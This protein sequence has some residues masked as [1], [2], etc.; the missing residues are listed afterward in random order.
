MLRLLIV[1]AFIPAFVI[2]VTAGAG[3]AGALVTPGVTKGAII[4]PAA[5]E[6]A[7]GKPKKFKQNKFKAQKFKQRKFK[8]GKAPG[9]QAIPG[10]PTG[11]FSDLEKQITRDFFRR[12]AG[13]VRGKSK[14]FPPGLAKRQTLPPGL[15]MQIQRNGILPPGLAKRTLPLGLASNL[16]ALPPG[17]Q[18][19]I[20]GNDVVLVQRST[21]LILDVLRG[22][23]ASR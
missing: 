2:A 21:G 7:K 22:A 13:N 5:I 9:G 23:L 19:L 4:V 20:V 15:A 12:Q 14:Q 18:R 1:P 10:V 6:L 16:P 8:P 17:Q 3:P 11:L